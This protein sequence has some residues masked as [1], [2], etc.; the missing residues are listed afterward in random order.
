M[1]S[2]DNV[3]YTYHNATGAAVK[4]VSLSVDR[5]EIVLCTGPSGCGKS[6]LV[7]L[8]NGL[9][10]HFY[11]GRLEGRV[12]IDGRDTA[13]S[14]LHAISR[15][16]GTLFQDPES[17]FFALSVEDE[18]A[19]AH[20]W[21]GA[22]PEETL[23]RVRDAAG[24]FGLDGIMGA[25]VLDLSEGQ[26]QKVALA[27]VISLGP[28]A[29]VLDEPSANLDPEATLAL[30]E[31]LRRLRNAGMAILVVDHR[32]YWLDGV[33]DRVAVMDDGRVVAQGDYSLLRDPAFR[34]ARGLRSNSVP[35]P[36][37]VL[38]CP[39]DDCDALQARGLCFAHKDGPETVPRRVLRP[40]HG[41]DG[42]PRSQRHGQDHPG[43]LADGAEPNPG[44]KAV[45]PGQT[46][47]PRRHPAGG[48]A[49]C[50]RTPTTSCTCAQSG[51]S[52]PWPRPPSGRTPT[53]AS[54]GCWRSSTWPPWP[55]G[56]PSP[57]PAERSSDW[58]SPAAWPRSPR[59]SSSTNRPAASTAAT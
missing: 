43:P 22:A 38:A 4:G 44:R 58:S 40:A 16:V 37:E 34:E 49:S 19:F 30:A 57:C 59:C 6:T 36:R 25:S 14:N 55:T 54:T 9:C 7:R 46:H 21:R 17:Q 13:T 53:V 20:E 28:A 47:E 32:L 26:K 3:T 18:L 11:R 45:F 29:I 27:A 1:L 24:A 52:W 48:P 41:R 56:T 50:C 2:F 10:P 5:G 23:A 8:A 15:S 33:A 39:G 31:E 12:A 35:D 51:P 42:A